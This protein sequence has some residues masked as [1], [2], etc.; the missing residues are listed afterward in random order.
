MLCS[1]LYSAILFTSLLCIRVIPFI[2]SI[3]Y[4]FY[5]RIQTY[6]YVSQVFFNLFKTQYINLVKI[7]RIVIRVHKF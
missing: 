2:F 3:P 1:K 7:V 5:F 6:A 4:N